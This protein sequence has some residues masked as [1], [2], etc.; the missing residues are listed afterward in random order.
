[1]VALLYDQVN[2]ITM[3]GNS[4]EDVTKEAKELMASAYTNA[5][6]CFYRQGN[7]YLVLLFGQ[8]ALNYNPKMTK[9]SFRMAQAYFKLGGLE[10]AKVLLEQVL[11]EC[12]GGKFPDSADGRE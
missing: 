4:K 1:M 2:S 9:A 10:E 12:P 8:L 3:L 7:Y 5:A 11:L 6:T